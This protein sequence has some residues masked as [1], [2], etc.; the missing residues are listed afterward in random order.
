M[1]KQKWVAFYAAVIFID[2]LQ[3]LLDLLA[4]G[5]IIN[6]GID[7]VVFFLLPFSLHLAGVNMTDPKKIASMLGAGTLEMLPGLDALPLWTLDLVVIHA[8]SKGKEVFEKVAPTTAKHMLKLKS[9]AERIRKPLNKDGVRLPQKDTDDEE[10]AADYSEI[11]RDT[12]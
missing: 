9:S 4:I 5:V 6:R 8:F 1:S 12:I 2:I 10:I 3:V 11:S 7:I